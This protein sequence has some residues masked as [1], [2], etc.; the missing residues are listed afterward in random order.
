MVE[1]DLELE[2]DIGHATV[3]YE[4]TDGEPTQVSVPNEHV[5]Y[6]QDHWTLKLDED[7]EGN[8]IVRRIPSRRVYFV[9][10]SVEEFEDEVGSIKNR[11]QSLANE[12]GTKLPFGDEDDEESDDGLDITGGDDE[13]D[14]GSDSGDE[15]EGDGEQSEGEDDEE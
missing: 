7:D 9:E 8:D 2:R 15:S 10:R 5:V 13:E 14:D 1:E 3:V 12:I 4:D 11:V 6:V